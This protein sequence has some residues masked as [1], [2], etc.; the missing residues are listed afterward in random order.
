MGRQNGGIDIRASLKRHCGPISDVYDNEEGPFAHILL[1]RQ[2]RKDA[3]AHIKDVARYDAHT[4]RAR[5]KSAPKVSPIVYRRSH[6]ELMKTE[7]IQAGVMVWQEHR[8]PPQIDEIYHR[9]ML[10]DAQHG[11]LSRYRN[12]LHLAGVWRS[13]PSMNF[14][15]TISGEA[16]DEAEEAATRVRR[17]EAHVTASL[18]HSARNLLRNVGED[19]ATMPDTGKPYWLPMLVRVAGV[20][21]AGPAEERR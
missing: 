11:T 12:D 15:R 17:V 20:M 2:R 19:G 8:D 18:G 10:T 14:G 9:R 13:P 21:A 5:L 6:G 4:R 16:S 3:L 1:H 7:T